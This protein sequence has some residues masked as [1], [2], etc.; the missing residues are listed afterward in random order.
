MRKTRLSLEQLHVESFA[1]DVADDNMG[2]VHGHEFTAKFE[3]PTVWTG[4]ANCLR[5]Q[6]SG[7]ASCVW[8][9]GDTDTCENCSWTDGDGFAC[10]W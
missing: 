10:Y 7:V 8:C 9:P 6:N 1:T 3:C 5:C 4:Q 2:T